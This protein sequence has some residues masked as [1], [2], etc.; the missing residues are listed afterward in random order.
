MYE[1]GKALTITNQM[2]TYSL[3]VLGLCETHRI[4]EGQTKLASEELFLYSGHI[5]VV[6]DRAQSMEINLRKTSQSKH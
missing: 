3:Q 2:R 4:Q 5:E 1:A 6:M